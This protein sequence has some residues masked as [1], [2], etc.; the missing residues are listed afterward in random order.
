LP[1]E[2]NCASFSSVFSRAWSKVQTKIGCEISDEISGQIVVEEFENGKM[3]WRQPLDFGDA[4]NGYAIVLSNSHLWKR[5]S[6]S[7]YKGDGGVSCNEALPMN[8]PTGGFGMMW[9][10]IAEIRQLLGNA[11]SG[12]KNFTN[13]TAMQEFT[14]GFMVL[15]EGTIYIFYADGSWESRLL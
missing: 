8:K 2:T 9:C 14:N 10:D 12:E 5:Y 11:V 13:G 7:P 3:L 6:H 1:T 15:V 4:S